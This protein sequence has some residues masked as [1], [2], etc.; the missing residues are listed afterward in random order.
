MTAARS[1]RPCPTPTCRTDA[2]RSDDALEL[3][4]GVGLM[5]PGPVTLL[6]LP[7]QIAQK[8]HACTT[9]AA[10]EAGWTNDRAHDLIDLQLL[11]ADLTDGQEQDV[12]GAAERLFASR[13]RHPW[14]PQ[15]TT[16]PGWDERYLAELQGVTD[17][18][19]LPDVHAAVDWL[20]AFI[21]R[22]QAR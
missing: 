19:L 2:V 17:A 7:M 3:F 16:R 14:P 9:P 12:R 18:E 13:R 15:A 20:N 21:E 4:A 11:I 10:P 6:P 1:T 5:A 22:L 8:L